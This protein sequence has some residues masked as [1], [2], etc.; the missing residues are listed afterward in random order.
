MDGFEF[1]HAVKSDKE[2]GSIPVV[3]HTSVY[4]GMNDEELVLRLGAE[5]FIPKPVKPEAF[6]AEIS[7]VLEGGGAGRRVT[8]PTAM[9]TEEMKYFREHCGIVAAKLEEKVRELEESLARRKEA[10]ETLVKLS[11]AVE[12]SPTAIVIT[13]K[14]GTI[15]FV[16][17]KFVQISGYTQEEALGEN[18]RILKS[19]ETSKEEYRS[20]WETI[21]SGSVWLGLFHNRR[22]SGELFWE[23]AT[24]S[25]IMNREGEITNFIAK[26]VGYGTG[27]GLAIVYGIV[28]QHG[29]FITICSKL[30]EGTAFTIL[31]TLVEGGEKKGSPPP[32]VIIPGGRRPSSWPMTM[33]R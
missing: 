20:L 4:T 11:Q 14:E 32:T 33:P 30:G 7:A 10:E 13:D 21:L 5:A 24:I 31:L 15:E 6:W 17:P 23:A 1:L 29:G 25:P 26:E 27:L 28:K 8:P 22:K 3:I 9:A 19:G 18:P 2:L 12:Q 16:N